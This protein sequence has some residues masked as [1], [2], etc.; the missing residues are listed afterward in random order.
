MNL[1]SLAPIVPLIRAF[2]IEAESTGAEGAAK[3]DAV[4]SAMA[5]IWPDIQA[6]VKE[7]RGVHFDDV[8]E[9]IGTVA[10]GVVTLLNAVFG[11]IWS[12]VSYLV[13]R[14]ED[15]LDT[16]LDGDGDIGGE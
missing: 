7:L 14:A 13:D 9:Y 6:S 11:K 1:A 10:D 16:D 8:E 5:A 3:R 15:W 2:V 4:V 12:F